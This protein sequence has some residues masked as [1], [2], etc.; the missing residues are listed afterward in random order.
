VPA[1]FGI[2]ARNQRARWFGVAVAA[3]NLIA[4]LTSIEAYPFWALVIVGIDVLV[5]YGLAAY[6][7]R[8]ERPAGLSHEPHAPDLT[9]AIV[10]MPRSMSRHCRVGRRAGPL[11]ETIGPRRNS[12]LRRRAGP[13]SGA[14]DKTTGTLPCLLRQP[15]RASPSRRQLGDLATPAALT[16]C[17]PHGACVAAGDS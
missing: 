13:A 4:A 14:R 7:D 2:F 11:V 9:Q 16:R 3:V 12:S 17:S 15:G 5:I 10:V 6:G 8:L 1:G